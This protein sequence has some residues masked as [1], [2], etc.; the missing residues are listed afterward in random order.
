[1]SVRNGDFATSYVNVH[2]NNIQEDVDSRAKKKHFKQ[3]YKLL[4]KILVSLLELSIQLYL[5]ASLIRNIW[6]KLNL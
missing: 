6:R 1:M 3:A 2:N 4:W 5:K